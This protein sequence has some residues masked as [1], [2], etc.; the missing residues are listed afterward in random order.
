M[1]YVD[2]ENAMM[3]TSLV[4]QGVVDVDSIILVNQQDMMF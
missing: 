1:A 4:W 3:I 2:T